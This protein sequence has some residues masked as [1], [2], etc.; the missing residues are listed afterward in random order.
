MFQKTAIAH[1]LLHVVCFSR[2][3]DLPAP[4]VYLVY[5][6]DIPSYIYSYLF[7]LWYETDHV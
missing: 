3:G 4:E 1:Q 6:T 5:N 2:I 7:A